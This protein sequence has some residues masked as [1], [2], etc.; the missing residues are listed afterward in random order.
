MRLGEPHTH[1]LDFTL[2]FETMSAQT[3]ACTLSVQEKI[4]DEAQAEE[5]L[6]AVSD[7]LQALRTLTGADLQPHTVYVAEKLFH[8][9]QRFENRV[10]CRAEDILSGAYREYLIAAALGLKERWKAVG[11]EECLTGETESA[12]L[13]LKLYFGF[14]KEMDLLSLS[15]PYFAAEFSNAYD[16]TV[17][18]QTAGLLCRHILDNHGYSA[19]AG[20][21]G[22]GLRT[23]WLQSIGV[24]REYADPYEGTLDGFT[25]ETSR[26][27]PLILTSPKGD[28]FYLAPLP[29]DMDTAAGVRAFLYDAITG[30]QKVI[31]GLRADAPEYADYMQANFAR[32]LKYYME[33]D[34]DRYSYANWAAQEIHIGHTGTIIHET[35]H[36]LTRVYATYDRYYMDQWKVEG[37][38]EY[39]SLRYGSCMTAKESIFWEMTELD[40]TPSEYDTE[41]E[42]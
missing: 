10:Y 26:K 28:I 25:W 22:D 4:Y 20:M 7:D 34:S 5:L 3:D 38:A 27:Y 2:W 9:V 30:P 18:R 31:D 14:S 29:G 40:L 16:R 42:L 11:L 12:G 39:L 19:L 37:L 33:P 36:I 8:G 32:P 6:R 1:T 35:M 15:A 41:Q 13:A 17:A 21:V 23:E 24:D